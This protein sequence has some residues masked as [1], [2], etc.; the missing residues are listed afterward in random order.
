MTF[1]RS[2]F[3]FFLKAAA[4]CLFEAIVCNLWL[5]F[6]P[7]HDIYLGLA[8]VG[9]FI[10]LLRLGGISL[11]LAINIAGLNL[12]FEHFRREEKRPRSPLSHDGL[13]WLVP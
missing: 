2:S 5:R 11:F 10:V 8:L 9:G 7:P 6:L 1:L 13:P 12:A 3:F 4:V